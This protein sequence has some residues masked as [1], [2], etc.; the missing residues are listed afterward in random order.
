MVQDKVE[1]KRALISVYDKTGLDQLMKKLNPEVRG[2]EIVSSGGTA[3]AISGMG[4]RV[5]EVSAYTGYL[6]SPDGLVKT[7]HPKIHGGLLMDPSKPAHAAY[8]DAIKFPEKILSTLDALSQLK[9][10]EFDA[11]RAVYSE[12][13]TY[14]ELTKIG[15]IDLFVGNLYPFKK[16]VIESPEDYEKITEMID[17]GGPTMLR[18]AAKRHKRVATL[19]ELDPIFLD[20]LVEEQNGSITTNLLGRL[21]MARKAYNHTASYETSIASFFQDQD[22]EKVR[23]WYFEKK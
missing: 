12:L 15:P 5:T 4:Y 8:M 17:I 9:Q 6:E 3:K 10:P 20:L 14:A 16:T 19:V 23:D 7:L 1:I 21:I 18:G 13:K 11:L 2:I 22:L